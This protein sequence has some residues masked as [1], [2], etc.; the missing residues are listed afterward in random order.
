MTDR[1]AAT[2][3]PRPEYVC[4]QASSYDRNDADPM[5][6]RSWFANKDYWN[7]IRLDNTPRGKEWGIME[8]LSPGC[9]TRIWLPI[10]PEDDRRKVRFY[11]DGNPEPAIEESL[12][13]LISG[14]AFIQSPFAFISSDEKTIRKAKNLPPG[15]GL[16]GA[17]FFLPISYVRSCRITL[18]EP[19]IY[20]VINYRSD[21][22][23]TKV[24]VVP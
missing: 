23:G 5:D 7:A 14:E 21:V 2:R 22:A 10:L 13:R 19:P 20:Y 18:N 16:V 3:W 9:V 11:L 8:D 4:R 6:Q 12:N 24:E 17:D 15:T 1:D